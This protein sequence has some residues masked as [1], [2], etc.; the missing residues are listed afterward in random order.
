MTEFCCKYYL[1][2]EPTS[3]FLGI[4]PPLFAEAYRSWLDICCSSG[5]SHFFKFKGEIVSIVLA[6]DY[7]IYA[8]ALKGFPLVEYIEGIIEEAYEPYDP[9]EPAKSV[10]IFIGCTHPDHIKKGLFFKL[11]QQVEKS[12]V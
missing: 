6:L 12:G 5:F 10:S 11:I 4:T 7:N 3:V 2:T 8:Q 1:T 9:K